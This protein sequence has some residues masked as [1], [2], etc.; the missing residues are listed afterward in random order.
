[1]IR[2]VGTLAA[3]LVAFWLAFVFESTVAFGLVPVVAVWAGLIAG[4]P[5]FAL[6][7]A[8]LGTFAYLVILQMFGQLFGE[9]P[10]GLVEGFAQV[11]VN[12]AAIFIVLAGI[13]GV[14]WLVSHRLRKRHAA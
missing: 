6:V 1:M 8:G 3:F 4:S 5:S 12:A 13:T 2:F 11:V 10:A 7:S 9:P 14:T